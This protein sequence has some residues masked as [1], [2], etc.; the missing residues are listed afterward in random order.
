MGHILCHK[1]RKTSRKSSSNE[2]MC[3]TLKLNID[4]DNYEKELK[5]LKGETRKLSEYK[6]FSVM[7][8]ALF[9]DEYGNVTTKGEGEPDNIVPDYYLLDTGVGE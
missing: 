9:Y 5:R 7:H 1:T 4:L 8:K 3:T 6:I 2:G